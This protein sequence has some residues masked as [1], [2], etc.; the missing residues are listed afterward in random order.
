MSARECL[1][2]QVTHYTE[3]RFAF[4]L[5][6]SPTSCGVWL[7]ST[8]QDVNCL[9]IIYFRLLSFLEE[10]KNGPLRSL[11]CLCVCGSVGLWVCGSVGLWAYGSVG[12]WV[13]GSVGLWV[14]GSVGLWV[15]GSVGLWVC[16][17]MGLWVCGSV[18]LWVCG[19]VGLWVCGSVLLCVSS[20]IKQ[21]LTDFHE[22]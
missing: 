6:I 14:C 4:A 18:R 11:Y 20:Q 8:N 5:D 17:S 12:L 1:P 2:A 22:T 19:S 13:C 16:G 21:K 9:C 7:Y 10:K 3:R 15:Y